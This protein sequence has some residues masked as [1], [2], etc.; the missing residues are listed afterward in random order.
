MMGKIK[1]K[2]LLLDNPVFVGPMA[3]VS[4]LSFR[5]ML[6]DF[7]PGLIYS[8]MISAQAILYENEK[9]LDMCRVLDEEHQVAL[10][11]FGSDPQTMG[12]AA[13]YIDQKTKAD[14]IDINMGCPVQ[15]VVKTGAG[16]SLMREVDRAHAIVSEM[17]SR[18]EKPVTTKIR[19]GWDEDSRNAVEMA[20]ALEA[21]GASMIAVH[22]R[23]RSQM[24]KGQVDREA[25]AEV[26]RS[27]SIPVIANGD[28]KTV[29]DAL[30]MFEETSADAIMISRAILHNPWLIHEIKA[31][32]KDEVY[33]EVMSIP[34]RFAW[35]RERFVLMIDLQGE[36]QA[37]RRMRGFSTWFVA[38]LPRSRELKMSFI[39]MQNLKEFDTIV[40][41]YLERKV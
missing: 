16:S 28:I 37:V 10:Q 27:V 13:E 9:T 18:V 31:A 29:D 36:A 24:Y 23:T 12:I 19:L 38:G 14:V 11:L 1:I 5:L 15:K 6:A 7:K 34:D 17:V 8:E 22:G 4:D 39:R 30:S 35:L 26:K 25:I 33:E 40:Q 41:D 21:A 32:L 3:G 20:Q 2:D